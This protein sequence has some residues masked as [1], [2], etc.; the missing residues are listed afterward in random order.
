MFMITNQV[1]IQAPHTIDRRVRGVLKWLLYSIAAIIL[2]IVATLI[3]FNWQASLRETKT[4]LEAAP[5][6]GRFVRA[7]DV[8]LFI[9]EM[10]P[11]SSPAILFIHGTGAWSE[12]W[13]ETMAT[14]AEAGFHTIAVDLPPFG[15]SERPA[16][17]AYGRGDQAKRIIALLDALDIP[18]ATLVGHSFGAGPTAEAT[19]LAP[20]RVQML[21]LVDPA[22]GLALNDQQQTDQSPL[23][24]S[25]FAVRS[26]R[27]AVVAATITNPLCTKQLLEL[28]IL[29]PADATEAQVKMLQ[30]PLVI[31]DST[32]TVGDWLLN[33]LT[34]YE[35]SLSTDLAQYQTLNMPVLIIWGD[36]DTIV[37]LAQGELLKSTIPEAELVIL[38]QVGH[39]PH[40]EDVKS[41]NEALLEFLSEHRS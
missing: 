10:G 40:I 23:L 1:E 27:N 9:Q 36:S 17:D 30:Q 6:A 12:I 39:I 37:P 21:V 25:L 7:G 24:N 41:F 26:L 13:R 18:R 4:R 33:F 22:L 15:F 11:A 2:L 35:T 3:V 32:D 34:V 19:L 20:D 16:N 29:D 38:K 14:L 31:K 8:E 5:Q 28:L